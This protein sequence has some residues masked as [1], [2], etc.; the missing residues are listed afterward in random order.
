MAA[1]PNGVQA[2]S[3]GDA[4]LLFG[5]QP[6]Y[7]GLAAP[8][9]GLPTTGLDAAAPTLEAGDFTR[10]IANLRPTG[11]AW[12]DEPG[13]VQYQALQ[14]L[15]ASFATLH[16]RADALVVEAFPGTTHELLSEW[17]GSVGLPDA[18]APLADT[19]A[20]RR[21]TMLA[22]LT[23]QGGASVPYLLAYAA[24]LG[25]PGSIQQFSAFRADAS[26]ADDP[27]NG[28][29]WAYAWQLSVLD[30]SAAYYFTADLAAADDPLASYRTGALECRMRR[31]AP[32]QTVLLFQYA[33]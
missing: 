23:A 6:L 31:V 14:A 8:L 15:A 1:F 20:Q 11:D 3:V 28:D 30:A 4:P 12:P 21:Q 2:L 19:I 9:A 25:S 26:A 13:S 7:F 33:A 27:D 10:L 16:A 22:K 5:G 17:E 32:A 24:A 18:C 29:D